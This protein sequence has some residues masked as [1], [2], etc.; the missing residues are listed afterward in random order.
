M[1]SWFY[2]NLSYVLKKK[3]LVL[4][5]ESLWV[6]LIP[7]CNFFAVLPSL[8]TKNVPSW[9]IYEE[10]PF[11]FCN[12]TFLLCFSDWSEFP[13][14]QWWHAFCSCVR[15]VHLNTTNNLV[16][17][18]VICLSVPTLCI[19]LG[20]CWELELC[21]SQLSHSHE[22]M[23]YQRAINKLSY[24]SDF[25]TFSPPWRTARILLWPRKEPLFPPIA[26]T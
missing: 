17:S 5:S 3:C 19:T 1:Y 16:F 24:P 14:G 15:A 26:W 7:H 6:Y 4:R 10:R 18:P 8:L 20:T 2:L 9:F 21:I 23:E 11:L 12:K 22:D 13:L 25:A